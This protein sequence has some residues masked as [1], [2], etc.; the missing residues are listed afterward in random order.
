MGRSRARTAPTNDFRGRS[1][2]PRGWKYAIRS[3]CRADW[4]CGV[5]CSSVCRAL[6]GSFVFPIQMRIWMQKAQWP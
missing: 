1:G 6:G 4:E 5:L 2:C 3:E